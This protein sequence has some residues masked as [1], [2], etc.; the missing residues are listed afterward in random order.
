MSIAEVTQNTHTVVQ[1]DEETVTTRV[2]EILASYTGVKAE[3]IPILQQVQQAFGYLPE[4]A[5]SRIAQFVEVPE[6][7]VF[8]VA[9]FYAQFKLVP[10]GR[11]II[12]VCRGT[13]CYVKGAPR[14]L[15]ET[16]KILGI[17]DGET[18]PDL[19]YTLETVA[20]FG[21]CA[22]APVMVVNDKVYGS[23]TTDKVKKI[24]DR[25]GRH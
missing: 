21:S 25:K 9:T 10:T 11:N 22:L 23:M 13:G 6:C 20:C 7:T 14:I 16:E 24:L 5:M 2:D 18:T 19:E 1:E 17:K 12:K 15:E 3:L 8:G 4:E